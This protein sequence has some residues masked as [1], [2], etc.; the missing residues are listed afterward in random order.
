MDAL[1]Q[2]VPPS[3]W[4]CLGLVQHLVLDVEQFWFRAVAVGEEDVIKSLRDGGDAW[5]AGPDAPASAILDRYRAETDLADTI[6]ATAA[7]TPWPGGPTTSPASHTCTLRD[8]LLHV[9]TETGCHAG[10]LDA[11]REVL[12]GRRWMAL[13]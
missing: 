9:I 3:G 4:N 5:Q 10:H 6:T 8:I 2:P 7:D 1:C 13:A 11:A 12:D